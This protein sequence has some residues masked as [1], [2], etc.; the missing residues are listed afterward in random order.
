MADH[1]VIQVDHESG[2]WQGLRGA[3]HTLAFPAGRS[4]L[5]RAARQVGPWQQ[6]ATRVSVGDSL[7]RI[8]APHA[9]VALLEPVTVTR[10][11]SRV[12]GVERVPRDSRCHLQGVIG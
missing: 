3:H 11:I 10:V 6:T 1:S 9:D 2:L 5:E 8:A 7:T 12:N 4:A